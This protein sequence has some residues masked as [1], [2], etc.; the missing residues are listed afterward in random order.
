MRLTRRGWAVVGIVLGATAMAGAFGV[1]SLGAV[2]VPAVLALGAAAVQGYRF[3][4]PTVER[5][6]PPSDHVGTS[7]EVTVAFDRDPP[8]HA[9]VHEETGSGLEATGTRRGVVLGE[10]SLTYEV[11]YRER[12]VHTLGPISVAYRDVLGLTERTVT[13]WETDRLLVYPRIY[14]LDAGIR[15]RLTG[16]LED[17]NR[18][19]RDEFDRLREYERGD[20]LRDIHWKSSGK[21][22]D[23]ELV[24]KE[25]LADDAEESIRLSVAA[26][27]GGGDRMATVAA[28]LIEYLLASGID[29]GLDAPDGSVPVDAGAPHRHE[30]FSVLATTGPGRPD[31]GE[32][33]DFSVHVPASGPVRITVG[34]R[35]LAVDR[36]DADAGA[37]FEVVP[38]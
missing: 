17:A 7:H 12:G 26:D 1:R 30:L 23:D 29:V 21:R 34:D 20:A 13:Q 8:V 15:S 19:S 28:S 9:I 24:V 5:D 37:G 16:L 36:A 14:R 32:P 22:P 10:E 31:V 25:F 11:T 18:S 3:D 27:E 35:S 6:L 38:A 4:A 33:S 2:V